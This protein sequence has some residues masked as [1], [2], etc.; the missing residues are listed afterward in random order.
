MPQL[1]CLTASYIATQLYLDFV[2]VILPSAVLGQIK[3]NCKICRTVSLLLRQV[4]GFS[5]FEQ[6]E[7]DMQVS[8]LLWHNTK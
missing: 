2:Q 3:Y 4:E 6:A 8:C 5:V 1:Y 7:V